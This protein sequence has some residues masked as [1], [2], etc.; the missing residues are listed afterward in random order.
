MLSRQF[1]E[2]FRVFF[3]V[4]AKINLNLTFESCLGISQR[5]YESRR[6]DDRAGLYMLF[7]LSVCVF[8]RREADDLGIRS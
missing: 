1:N 5:Y 2:A 4:Y 7:L 6:P 3:A 8:W